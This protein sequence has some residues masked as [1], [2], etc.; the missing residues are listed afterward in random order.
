MYAARFGPFSGH[1]PACQYKNLIKEDKAVVTSYFTRF[2]KKNNFIL[3]DGIS[4]IEISTKL[5]FWPRV[6]ITGSMCNFEVYIRQFQHVD[7]PLL[8]TTF[9]IKKIIQ[10]K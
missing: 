5:Y 7:Y 3:F 8:L 1:H 6:W 9:F 10:Q 4:V 2:F